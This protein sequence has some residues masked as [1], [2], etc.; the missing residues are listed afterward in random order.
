[1]LIAQ[2]TDTHVLAPGHLAY[3]RVDT[4]A[5]LAQAVE[6]LL[7]EDPRPD[8]VLVTGDLA[9][10]GTPEE[11]ANLRAL[12]APLPMPMLVIA[13]NHDERGPL[14]EAFAD[15]A[16]LPQSGFLHYA[17]EDYPLRLVGLDTVI[18]GETGGTLC[19][20]RIAW[21]EA[22]LAAAPRR[23]TA[24]FMHHPPFDTGIEGMDAHGLDEAASAALAEVVRR[25]PQVERIL[26]GH[27]H[28]TIQAR[29]GGTLASV[30]PS[31]AHQVSLDLRPGVRIG[32]TLEPP[33]YHLHRYT[34]QS[35][36]V[37]HAVTI[38]DHAGPFSF[39]DGQPQNGAPPR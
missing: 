32:F 37:T 11:Y 23:P 7:R 6:T 1:M 5:C 34:P 21:L 10:R 31:T 13:G 9:H 25:H 39:R 4:N 30:A 38:G 35:G 14:A 17:V 36:L 16:Y 2:I 15:H 27:V 26:A 8:L 18:A 33:G 29:F 22:T 28:R 3:G 19:A 24:I 12:L 20:E